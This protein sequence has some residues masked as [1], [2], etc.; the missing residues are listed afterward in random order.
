MTAL[1]EQRVWTEAELRALPDNGYDFELVDGELVMSPKN[2]PEHG[3]ICSR[4]LTAL[5]T[6][7]DA[8]KLGAVWDS[9]TGYWMVNRNCRAPDISFVSKQR[10]RG[11]KRP[12]RNFFEGA[13]DLVVEVLSPDDTRRELD[14]RL[15][16]F[17]SSGTRLAWL[18]DPKRQMIEVCR[19]LTERRLI[20]PDGE[21]NGEDVVPGFRYKVAELFRE[22]N[23]E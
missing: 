8:H 3:E 5:K 4:A 14:A 23:W 20:G 15:R 16:D 19:S 1:L 2:N 12:P 13:P 21:L 10:L 22:W 11:M 6:Y 9:S 18:I 7:T 17:F